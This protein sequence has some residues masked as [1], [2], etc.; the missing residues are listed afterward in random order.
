MKLQPITVTLKSF[1]VINENIGVILG[2][3]LLSTN[4]R[5]VPGMYSLLR[6]V[7]DYSDNLNLV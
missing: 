7:S 1:F 6:K 2:I 5:P 3:E 4:Q